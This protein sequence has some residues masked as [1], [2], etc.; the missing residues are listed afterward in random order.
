MAFADENPV[1]QRIFRIG[2][3]HFHPTAIHQANQNFG[4]RRGG[5]EMAFLGSDHHFKTFTPE[6]RG[7]VAEEIQVSGHIIFLRVR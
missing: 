3:I 1:S 7:F 6:P 5:G 4:A 2:R